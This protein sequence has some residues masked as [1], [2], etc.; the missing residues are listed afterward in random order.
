[1]AKIRSTGRGAV[2][3]VED[4]GEL[5][6]ALAQ[7]CGTSTLDESVVK[8]CYSRIGH[9]VEKWLSDQGRAETSPVARTLISI[10][11]NLNEIENALSGH[12]TGVHTSN[13]LAVVSQLKIQLAKDR[14]I[15][16]QE[17]AGNLI[18]SFRNDARRIAH[19]SLV[20]AAELADQRGSKGRQRLNWYDDFTAILLDIAK[21]VGIEPN[22][23]K[24][25]E[26][27]IRRGWL[28]DAALAL[29]AFLYPAMR[30]STAEACGKRLERSKAQLQ[31]RSTTK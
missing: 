15:G 24:D 20:A 27:G 19:S 8:E 11:R 7:L 1:M 6:R 30:S 12:D 13:E 28:L 17:G 4:E 25:R 9:I 2:S 26:T 5:R 22:L 10:H 29:E 16:S 3:L 31:G 14:S 23:Q 21:G 18:A